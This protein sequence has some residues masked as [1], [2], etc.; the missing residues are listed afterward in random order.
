MS[1]G[2]RLAT[3]GSDQARA[4]SQHVADQLAAATGEQVELVLIET[5]GDRLRDR[6]IGEIGG[7]G[8]FT[9]E[10]Q[11]AVVDGRADIAVHSAKDLPSS[12]GTPGLLL[13][14]VPERNDPRDALVGSTLAGL[15]VGALVATGSARRLAQLAH[16]RPDLRFQGL[17]GN[18]PTR[19]AKASEAEI[20]AVVVAVAG[21]R[22]VG[23]EHELAEV[24]DVATMVPQVGQGALAIECRSDDHRVAEA[25]ALVQHADSRRRVDA[26]R[27][28]LAELGGGCDL[29]VGAHAV[30][31]ADGRLEV[32]G[33]LAS[34]GGAHLVRATM[35][36]DDVEVGARLAAQLR[37]DGGDAL[38]L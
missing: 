31:L 35:I 18:I 13:A 1:G 10:V 34:H 29:P 32:H 11:H 25:L 15:R 36:G 19:V 14:C 24:L 9:K 5:Q 20:D 8:V 4:Q 6:P 27:S 23:L 38:G 2:F 16:A 21:V 7:R 28:F 17:R 33:M 12:F 26:E 37:T 30:L 3:R 22:W